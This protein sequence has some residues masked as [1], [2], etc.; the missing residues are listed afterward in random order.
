M[1]YIKSLVC[2][3][4]FTKPSWRALNSSC[5]WVALF[6]LRKLGYLSQLRVGSLL[7]RDFLFK[8]LNCPI[9]PIAGVAQESV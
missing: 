6:I 4:S 2:I 8:A 3:K 7:L 5:H 9:V 1:L